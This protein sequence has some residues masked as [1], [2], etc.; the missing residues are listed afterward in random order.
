M[1]LNKAKYTVIDVETTGNVRQGRMT[2]ICII[3]I[4]N[5]KITDVWSSLINPDAYIPQNIIALTGITNEMVADAPRFHE[6]ASIV[7]EKTRDAIFVAHNVSFDFGF[8]EKE[9]KMVDYKFLRKKLCTVRLSRK[10]IPGLPS[11]SLGKLC[12]SLGISLQGAHRAEADTR[13]TATLFLTLLEIDSVAN[14]S[15][16]FNFLNKSSR[17]GT[18]PPHISIEDFNRLPTTTG[19]YLFKDQAGKILYVGKA[20]NIQ[21]RV[22]SHLYSKTQKSIDQCTATYHLD[23]VETGNELC[24]LLLEAD[25]IRKFYPIYNKAQKRPVNT[26]QIISYIN[27]KG[28]IQ[29]ALGKTKSMINSVATIYS[30]VV[31]LERLMQVCERYTL[32]PK[33]CTLQTTNA[34]CSH[35]KIK[36]C[37]GIC[38]GDEDVAVYNTRVQEALVQLENEKETFIIKQAGRTDD[39]NAIV[40]IEQGQ[41]KGFGF[42]N[43]DTAVSDFEQLSSQITRYANNHHTTKLIAGFVQK[44]VSVKNIIRPVNEMQS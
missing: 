29:L 32:C 1:E 14:F 36:D 16:F 26:F 38:S 23:F 11:Y 22:L 7:E 10:L 9:F 34:S 17:Q 40:L 25:Y 39:E 20:K 8:L 12:R 19:I 33:Y 31:G 41:Y 43:I 35:Y 21:S 27:Q 3:T 44:N 37:N 18:M 28:V 30:Q 5:M 42:I 13:A 4:E 6:I 24:A 15:V 2:E